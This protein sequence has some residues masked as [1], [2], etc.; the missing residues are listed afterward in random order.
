MKILLLASG[1]DASGTNRFI[2]E[3]YS[4]FKNEVYFA[5]SG[6]A[7]LVDGMIFPLSSCINKKLRNKAGAVIRSSRYPKFKEKMYFQKGLENAKNFDVVIILGGNGSQ[8]GAKELHE[9]GVNTI[10]VPA[11]IDN[12]VD[13][14]SYSIGF[15]TAVKEGVYA[16]ENSMPSIE[17]MGNACLF[18]VMG[19]HCGAIADAVGKIVNADHVVA[20]KE[21]LDF[22][23]IKQIVLDKFIKLQSACIIVRE[24][25]MDVEKISKKINEMVGM[26]I[27]KTQIVG[28]TQRGGSP[29]R[30]ELLMSKKFAKESINCIKNKVFGVSILADEN[31]K[32][33]V[34]KF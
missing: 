21:D 9:N 17:T 6:F 13:D 3:I 19:R 10:F 11:T 15:S 14:C 26:E 25:I 33:V 1:G 22:E 30:E 32:T 28:R 18:E 2:W 20:S 12:D 29:T 23:K 16:V 31:Y 5:Q 24:N 8:K 27:V 4:S 34:K 7:G